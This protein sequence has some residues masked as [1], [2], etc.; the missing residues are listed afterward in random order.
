MISVIIIGAGI[1]GL[2]VGSYLQ[3]NGYKTEIFELH[4]KAGGLCTTWKRNGYTIDGCVHWWV[5][6]NPLDPFYPVLDELLDMKSLSKVVYEEFC[7]VEENGKRLRFFGNLDQFERELKSISP[8]DSNGIDELISGAREVASLSLNTRSQD[9]HEKTESVLNAYNT[10]KTPIGEYSKKFKSPLIRKLFSI[11]HFTPQDPLFSFLSLASSFHNKN[12]CYSLGG[13][14]ELTER[15]IRRYESLGGKIHYKSRVQKILVE[16]GCAKGIKLQDNSSCKADYVISAADGHHTICDLLEGK[17]VD[18]TIEDL[19]FSEKHVPT[20]S[21]LYL[22][23]GV[24]RTFEDSFKPYVCFPLK[25][26]LKIADET[27]FD[28]EVTIRNFE[29]SAAPAGKTV[30]TIMIIVNNTE[31]WTT[32]RKENRREYDRQ[33]ATIAQQV[34]DELDTYFG[35]IKEKVEMIDV[36]TPATYIRY[37]NNWN[38]VAYSW[39]DFMLMSFN[40]PNKEIQGLN[41]FYMCGQWVGDAGIS[42]AS[43]SGK[44]LAQ[45]LCQ[46]DGKKFMKIAEGL[47]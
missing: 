26:P 30:L 7:S 16:N 18:T 13:A 1:A 14:Q 37:T 20:R 46:K 24:E 36:A 40:K 34:L 45:I 38:G 3:Q 28:V 35:N 17:Y 47:H 11:S 4:N 21:I 9:E 44:D 5:G 41:N 15:L 25:Q 2:S 19:Y 42:G 39:E 10:W 29:P 33:K 6:C 23:F 32:L 12:A 31:Y 27:I 22:S 8:E 43:Q